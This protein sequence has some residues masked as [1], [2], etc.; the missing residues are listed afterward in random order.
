MKKS[1]QCLIVVLGGIVFVGGTAR[2]DAGDIA[3]GAKVGTL[4][5]GAEMT[6]GILP[7]LNARVGLNGFRYN[8]D[9]KIDEI[10]YDFDLNL[11][12][13]VLLADWHLLG[14]AFRLSGGLV[15]NQNEIDLKARTDDDYFIIDNRAYSVED[16]G[17]LEGTIDFNKIS[18]YLGIGWGDAV[19]EDKRLSFFIDL[20]VL[21]QGSPQATMSATGSIASDPDFQRHLKNEEKEI[22][23]A[24]ENYKFYPVIAIGVAYKF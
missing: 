19:G 22:E 10:D 8:Y 6:I 1:L 9:R 15:L 11:L 20:G 14:S 21:F 13:G 24:A 17:D 5:I 3:L 16:V 23:D 7:H 12:S 2:A 18:P 4:G